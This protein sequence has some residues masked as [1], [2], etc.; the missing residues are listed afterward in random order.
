MSC[1][2]NT[3]DLNRHR[4]KLC[5]ARGETRLEVDLN[6]DEGRPSAAKNTF[7]VV[8]RRTAELDLSAVKLYLEGQRDMD[9]DVIDCITFLDHLL[10]ET[11]SRNHIAL[12]RSFFDRTT[13]QRATLGYGIEA[14]KGVYQSIR[15]GQ[16]KCLVVNVDVSN[17]VFWNESPLMNVAMQV[18]GCKSF[19]ELA[20]KAKKVKPAI[21]KPFQES[22]AMVQM[23]K[24]KKNN[25]YV[26]HKDRSQR[27]RKQLSRN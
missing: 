19:Q 2:S 17:S 16:G 11:P 27:E 15:F 3:A 13:T 4:A 18:S 7:K 5:D 22:A 10:R 21:D 9:S 25:F 14:M 20:Q 23:R 12:R 24:L 8:I 6:L 26:R 1:S